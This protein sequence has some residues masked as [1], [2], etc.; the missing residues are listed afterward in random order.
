MTNPVCLACARNA[1]YAAPFETCPKH[2]F[3]FGT[4]ANPEAP[5]PEASIATIRRTMILI[6]N[7]RRFRDPDPK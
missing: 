4:F 1:R 3:A 5:V 7:S 6:N 2:P